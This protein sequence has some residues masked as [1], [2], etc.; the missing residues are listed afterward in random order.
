MDGAEKL[1]SYIFVARRYVQ[2]LEIS[3]GSRL[4]HGVLQQPIIISALHPSLAWDKI[5]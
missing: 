3:G 4:E 5:L 1:L 2:P